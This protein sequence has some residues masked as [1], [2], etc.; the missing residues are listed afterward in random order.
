MLDP[1]KV[2][3]PPPHGPPTPLTCPYP[4]FGFAPPFSF[5]WPANIYAPD[6][7]GNCIAYPQNNPDVLVL[8]YANSCHWNGSWIVGPHGGQG[9]IRRGVTGSA[10][11]PT[12]WILTFGEADTYAGNWEGYK[13]SGLSPAGR[14]ISQTQCGRPYSVTVYQV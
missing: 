1:R 12:A 10:G 14:Y 8:N 7:H 13:F 3:I 4:N 11:S 2:S 9:G 5:Q 6:I